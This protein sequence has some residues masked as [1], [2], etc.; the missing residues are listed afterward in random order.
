MID[1]VSEAGLDVGDWGNFKG[2]AKKA[3][4][5][6]KYCY[7]WCFTQG[8][9]F[10][11]NFWFDNMDIEDNKIVQ[12]I[13]FRH[14]INNDSGPR[15]G[16]AKHF[17]EVA[18]DAFGRGISVR[19]VILDRKVPKVGRTDRRLLDPDYWNVASYDSKDGWIKF[20]RGT[21]YTPSNSS[22]DLELEAFP[23][24]ELRW[25][26]VKH[27]S[28]ENRLREKKLATSKKENGGR[29]IC[30]VPGCGFDFHSKYGDIGEGYA[31]V[32]HKIP[33]GSAGDDGVIT[34]ISDLA[35][36]CANCHAMIHRG[37]ECRSLDELIP[38]R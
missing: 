27:R 1:L 28:R 35:V 22:L 11:F 16:R 34:K 13:N 26:F 32:H 37:G 17:E 18:A 5:N 19:A 4:A 36:V 7:E 12:R 33:L 24:G 9:A 15:V 10:L 20:V 23:E 25:L 14:I 8:E 38:S 3:A 31:H 30:E 29:L 2:G 21:A 6:P